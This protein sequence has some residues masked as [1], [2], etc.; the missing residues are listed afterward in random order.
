MF[1]AVSF[2]DAAPGWLARPDVPAPDLSAPM[3]PVFARMAE[4]KANDLVMAL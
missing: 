1:E 3:L 4:N 2:A